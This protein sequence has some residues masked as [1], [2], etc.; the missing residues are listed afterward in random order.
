MTILKKEIIQ[1][2]SP[3]NELSDGLQAQLAAKAEIIF[4]EPAGNILKKNRDDQYVHYLIRG[5]IEVRSSFF[6]RFSFNHDDD[7]AS[8]SLEDMA[9]RNAQ[10]TATNNCRIARFELADID[11]ATSEAPLPDYE[12]DELAGLDLETA[13]VVED[14]NLNADWMSSFLHSP[15]VNHLSARDIQELLAC[16]EDIPFAAGQTVVRTGEYGDDFY[17]VKGGLAIVR[18]EK[19]GP[20][21]GKEFSLMPG[22]YFGEEALV[23]KTIRNAEVYMETDGV[24]GRIDQQAFNTF[25]RDALVI[26]AQESSVHSLLAEASEKNVVLDVRLYPEFRQGHRKHSRNLP[27]ALLREQLGELDMAKHY[28]ITPEGGS[29]SELATFIMR[30]AGFNAV[31]IQRPPEAETAEASPAA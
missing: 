4:V 23:G 14:S 15:L 3:F 7:R 10:V 29:R 8:F 19:H 6:E 5:E 2:F 22:S 21:R 11:A 24:L 26:K 12:L 31:L 27:L 9:G 13:Y 28:Y 25:I 18:T 30:Q 16:M 17:V 20:Y 1:T